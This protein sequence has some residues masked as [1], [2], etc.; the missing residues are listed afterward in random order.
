MPMLRVTWLEGRTEDQKEQIASAIVDVMAEV[1][2]AFR[3]RVDVLFE[4][5]PLEQ[6]STGGIF[7][8]K[9]TSGWT[10]TGDKKS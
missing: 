8:S 10:P 7:A 4:D 3:D 9:S 1:G 2:N 6:W 5:I